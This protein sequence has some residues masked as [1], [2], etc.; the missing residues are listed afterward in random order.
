MISFMAD[1]IGIRDDM[2]IGKGHTYMKDFAGYLEEGHEAGVLEQRPTLVSLQCDIDHP[3]SPPPTSCT[4]STPS[5]G[6]RTCA[7]RSSR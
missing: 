3:A 2:Y 5:A 4:W 1:V 6:S 7:A